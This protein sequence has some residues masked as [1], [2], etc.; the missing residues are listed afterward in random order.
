MLF[1]DLDD[2]QVSMVVNLMEE[3]QVVKDEVSSN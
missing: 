3:V 1:A 2:E